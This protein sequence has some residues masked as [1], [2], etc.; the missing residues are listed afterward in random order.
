[1][2][3]LPVIR[4]FSICLGGTVRNNIVYTESKA[5]TCDILKKMPNHDIIELFVA[6]WC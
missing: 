2:V 6:K 1:M 3:P 5:G 4:V